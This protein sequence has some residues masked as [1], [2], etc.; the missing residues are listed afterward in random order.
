MSS[1]DLSP[2]TYKDDAATCA[3]SSDVQITEPSQGFSG[4]SNSPAPDV[5]IDIRDFEISMDYLD[6]NIDL[7]RELST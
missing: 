7:L 6:F 3:G 2:S 1:T 5:S 4:A